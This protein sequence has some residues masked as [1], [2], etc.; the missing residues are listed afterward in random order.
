M[1]PVYSFAGRTGAKIAAATDASPG[2]AVF[3]SPVSAAAAI[4]ATQVRALSVDR[5]TG[6]PCA[7]GQDTTQRKSMIASHRDR[8][9]C[10][11]LAAREIDGVEA[12][13]SLPPPQ[14]VRAGS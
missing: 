3:A 11:A 5:S 12:N 9:E 10:D 1:T 13:E 14:M 6:S 8:L 2:T 7:V 4:R